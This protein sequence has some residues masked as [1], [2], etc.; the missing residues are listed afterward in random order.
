LV[1]FYLLIGMITLSVLEYGIE[2][3]VLREPEEFAIR[4]R[5]VGAV[6]NGLFSPVSALMMA[7]LG[8]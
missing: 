3:W 7:L 2:A 8:P 6:I 4:L 1:L 5:K